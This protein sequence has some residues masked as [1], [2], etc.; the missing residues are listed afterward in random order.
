MPRILS[1]AG[2]LGVVLVGC[3]RT[4]GGVA[5]YNSDPTVT[6]SLPVDEA[7]FPGETAITFQGLVSDDGGVE[8]LSISWISSID[9]VL[10]DEVLVDEA[11]NVELVTAGLSGGTHV[12]SLRAIDLGAQFGEAQITVKIIEIPDHPT[13][14]VVHP[15]SG[16][17][18]AE[19]ELFRFE[20]Q[21]ADAKDDPQ[22][23][24]VTMDSDVDGVDVCQMQPDAAGVAYCDK[25]LTFGPHNLVFEARDSEGFVSAVSAYFEVRDANDIDH[26]FDGFTEN[27][28][29]CD[30]ANNTIYPAAPEI[31][32]QKDQDCDGEIDEDSP[33]TDDD[34]DGFTELEG[35]CDDAN[36]SINPNGVEIPNGLDDDCDGLI[37]NGT[38]K[39]DDDGDGYCETPPCVNASGTQPDCDDTEYL[40]SPV[41]TEVCDNVDNDCDFYI[42]E[43]NAIGCK[44]WTKDVDGDTYG[45]GGATECHC[46]LG[47]PP[48][49]GDT[50]KQQDCYDNNSGAYPGAPG[51]HNI[52]RGDGSFDW[53]C[54]GNQERQYNQNHGSCKED[55]SIGGFTFCDING[56]GF[57]GGVPQCGDSGFWAD[58]CNASINGCAII[59]AFETNVAACISQCQGN[60]CNPE[61]GGRTQ[62]CR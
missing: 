53:N 32:D 4:P 19:N 7:E 11:G 16:E 29:D 18:A 50:A 26:D 58:D 47:S 30:D 41:G 6:I 39:Y 40:T 52:S 44:P 62:Q 27:Q 45:V 46:N 56:K 12:I 15:V 20:V 28:G 38:G 34:G 13:I 3:T 23:I 60:P 37:D 54:D 35:D 59:C 61:G 48:F 49:T 24:A 22:Q 31:C 17:A 1:L 25:A 9:D 42:D 5:V 21:V 57:V 14:N 10:E 33:C 55:F 51:W 8:N 43:K 36:P 2:L